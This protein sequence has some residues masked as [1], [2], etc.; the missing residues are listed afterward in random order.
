M[1]K[2]V[3]GECVFFEVV[4]GE[5]TVYTSADREAVLRRTIR[6]KTR[7]LTKIQKQLASEIVQH[8]WVEKQLQE[9]W[10]FEELLAD[11]CERWDSCKNRLARNPCWN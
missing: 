8:A 1:I 2:S 10:S 4:T 7:E 11:I 5:V 3:N 9:R 6:E